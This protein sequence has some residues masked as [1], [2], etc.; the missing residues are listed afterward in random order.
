MRGHKSKT[1]SSRQEPE[2]ARN[3]LSPEISSGSIALLTLLFCP[4]DTEFELLASRTVRECIS[5]VLSHQ[6]FGHGKLI[7]MHIFMEHL[8]KKL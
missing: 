7:I 6:V 8:Y 4:S 3:R 1:A 2:E 5:V